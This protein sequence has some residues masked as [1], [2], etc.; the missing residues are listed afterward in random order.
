M[1]KCGQN[2]VYKNI[3]HM[4][5]IV[6]NNGYVYLVKDFEKKGFETYYNL[7]KDPDSEMWKEEIEEITKP[8][9]NKKKKSN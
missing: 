4:E 9:S 8:K 3:N 5:K 2:H 1:K 7:G 6:K